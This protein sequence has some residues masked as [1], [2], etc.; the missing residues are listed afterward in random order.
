MGYSHSHKGFVCYDVSNCRFRISRNVTFFEDQFM[1]H[2]VS[3]ALDDVVTLPNFSIMP[4][5]IERYK[6]G[7]V[8]VRKSR[9]QVPMPLPDTALPPAP[10]MVEPRRSGRI[11]R[12][13]DRYSPD[14]YDASHTSLTASLSS[15]SIPP[16]YSQ[17]V[18]DVRWIKA[19]NEELQAFQ[20]NFTWDIVSCPP[21]VKPIGCKWV[22]SVKLN[23][24]GSLDRY[25]ARL[26]ALGN[27][28]EYG[29]DYDE[30][31]APVAKMTTV[32]TVISIAASSGWSLHQMDVKNAFLHG[33]LTED[34]Y[35]TPP[36][37]LFSSYKGV[38]KLKRSLYGLKQAPRAWY[39][40]FRS[41]LLGF[42]FT[43]SQ[44]D[45]SLFIHSTS[46]GIVLLLL[47]VDDMVI[48]GSDLASIQ[49]LK[50][51]LQS[52][53]HMKDLGT[54][55]F[56]LGL[57]V[58]S[59]SKG[60][61]LHQHKYATDL[62]SMA[63]LESANPVD[64]PL[65]VNVKYHRDDGDLL[66]DPL[67]YR[68]LVAVRRI[69]RYLK[70][71]SHRGLFFPT[72]ITP[73][74][75]AYSDADWAGCPDTRRSVTGWCMFLGSSLISWKSKKQARVSKSSTESEYHA[76]S[77]ACS[78]I[79]WLRGLLAELGFPQ[80]EPTS[81]YADNTSAIQIVANIV[82]HERTKHIEVDCHSIRD[83]YDGRLIALPHV[84]T[85]FQ[86]ADILTKAVPRPRHQFLVSKLMLLDKPHQ[87]EGGWRNAS[88]V[89][90]YEGY[91]FVFF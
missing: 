88:G 4:E 20:E 13:P 27:K 23:S 38:C 25:K 30:T 19:M 54:L 59:T 70:G 8:Y 61:L 49:R 77:A 3:P 71:T 14:R 82:F 22:Y 29:I 69:I 72:G 89:V 18:K 87:F 68:Q 11:S 60:I 26:V 91:L 9:Q 33:D 47:Y 40:K 50:Q 5:S 1:F 16:C 90:R 44:Y 86:V 43:Q 24:D 35:M 73:K 31:F 53:F 37:D 42:S 12:A 66:P 81:L 79:I 76:M 45:S 34:I 46:A 56:F 48:T 85:Q 64:T 67:L 15:I 63:G 7:Y 39:E 65:E 55:H 75:S 58:H 52:A 2:R 32:R 28:Q 51:Q 57:E 21:D 83:A 62:I 10:A 80:T 6:P 17:A 78:K 74:L 41:T 36:Q 84:S